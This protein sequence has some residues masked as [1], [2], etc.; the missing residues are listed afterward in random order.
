VLIEYINCL[1]PL[2]NATERLEG[3]GETGKF[4]ALYEIILVFKYLL[5]SLENSAKPFEHVNFN[6]HVK[7]P[8]DYLIINLRAA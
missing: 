7:A 3:R 2:K 4:G 8:K 1:R 6:A 5:R